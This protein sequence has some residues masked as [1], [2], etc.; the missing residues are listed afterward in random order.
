MRQDD[1]GISP[2]EYKVPEELLQLHGDERTIWTDAIVR[3]RVLRG[4]ALP[5]TSGLHTGSA[6]RVDNAVRAGMRAFGLQRG[7]TRGARIAPLGYGVRGR[8]TPDCVIQINTSYVAEMLGGR[9]APDGIF[10]TW[11]HESLHARKPFAAPAIVN[12]E[13]PVYQGYEE[14]MVEG[15]ARWMTRDK[16]GMVYVS[17]YA[18]YVRAYE[19]LAETL[20]I[21]T[22]TLWRHLWRHPF[23]EV[24]AAFPEEIGRIWYTY[25]GRQPVEE[26]LQGVADRL[27]SIHERMP[28]YSDTDLTILW[29]EALDDEE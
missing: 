19:T 7:R 4:L 14:G 23:G 2:P 16:A 8:K 11:V 3:H 18:S 20:E 13:Y 5:S 21:E 10:K 29:R 9:G 25:T 27:L 12:G 24:R 26:R 15:L 1:M 6:L 22:V 17:A 28:I